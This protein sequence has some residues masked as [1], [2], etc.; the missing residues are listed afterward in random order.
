[1]EYGYRGVV[2]RDDSTWRPGSLFMGIS[3]DNQ[4]QHFVL[5]HALEGDYIFT[6]PFVSPYI[7]PDN[8]ATLTPGA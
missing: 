8:N 1:M 6:V 4:T 3:M 2:H 7:S 5:I